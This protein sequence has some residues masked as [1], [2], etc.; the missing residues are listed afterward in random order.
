MRDRIFHTGFQY[1]TRIIFKGICDVGM[2]CYVSAKNKANFAVG[3]LLQHIHNASTV[4]VEDKVFYRM[5]AFNDIIRVFAS[6][7]ANP[8]NL[9]VGQQCLAHTLSHIIDSDGIGLILRYAV[10]SG[11]AK[12]E[13]IPVKQINFNPAIFRVLEHPLP[14][15]DFLF[16]SDLF[17]Q[18]QGARFVKIHILP[19]VFIVRINIDA[20]AIDI[21]Q[22]DFGIVLYLDNGWKGMGRPQAQHVV[23][24]AREVVEV[25]FPEFKV[26]DRFNIVLCRIS[27]V[28]VGRGARIQG[29]IKFNP[30]F[31]HEGGAV[32]ILN[33]KTESQKVGYFETAIHC[34]RC[35]CTSNP[36]PGRF[37][38]PNLKCFG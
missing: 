18:L 31:F 36:Y 7:D 29:D 37:N 30:A 20:D 21:V 35:I 25:G 28:V 6:R 8:R 26:P 19:L 12:S 16:D 10:F 1:A 15:R 27:R 34:A 17:D 3:L 38:S 5:F 14:M 32:L 23:A 4:G 11:C 22:R 2:V 33:R 13:D 9:R 24:I